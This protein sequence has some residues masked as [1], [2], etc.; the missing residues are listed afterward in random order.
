MTNKQHRLS[1]LKYQLSQSKGDGKNEVI[2]KLST[3]QLEYVENLGY[4]TI[5]WLY[6]IYTKT[7]Y[8]IK[9][10]DSSLIKDIH[11]ACKKGRK[12]LY[13]KLKLQEIKELEKYNVS[14]RGY[15][16]KIIL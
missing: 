1:G 14:Y 5:P 8:R 12:K 11:Y 10:V 6:E 9:D 4:D 16:Y 3:E 15:K 2:K 13:R 7:F